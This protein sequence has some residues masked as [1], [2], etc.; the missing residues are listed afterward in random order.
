MTLKSSLENIS[1]LASQGD[2]TQIQ[3]TQ[4]RH[5]LDNVGG[6]VINT[7]PPL[8][9]EAELSQLVEQ[10]SMQAGQLSPDQLREI[11]DTVQGVLGQ[12]ESL[13]ESDPDIFGVVG[14][15]GPGPGGP[16]PGGPGPGGPGPGGPGPGGPGP[17]GGGPPRP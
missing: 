4:I 5:E 6:M 7:D 9:F 14:P 16:G 1:S 10:V 11:Q 15:G 2:L 12:L 3:L 17:G 13:G 8:P